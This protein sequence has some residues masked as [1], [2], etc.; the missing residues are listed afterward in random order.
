MAVIEPPRV[1]WAGP[2]KATRVC[3]RC[4]RTLPVSESPIHTTRRRGAVTKHHVQ[5]CRSCQTAFRAARHTRAAARTLPLPPDPHP[6]RALRQALEIRRERGL[7]WSDEVF[8]VLVRRI[9]R[10]APEIR[11]E[12]DSW[13]AILLEQQ[14]IWRDAYTRSGRALALSADLAK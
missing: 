13:P 8:E 7:G 2:W 1:V 3:R 5:R 11:W 6:A 12:H 4:D 10:K 9:C 14:P